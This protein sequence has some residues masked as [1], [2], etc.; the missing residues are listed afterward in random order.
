MYTSDIPGIGSRFY[1]MITNESAMR[2][3]ARTAILLSSQN[4]ARLVQTHKRSVYH[5]HNW[6]CIKRCAFLHHIIVTLR[7]STNL[8]RET[9]QLFSMEHHLAFPAD[10][11]FINEQR[12][13]KCEEILWTIVY[14]IYNLFYIFNKIQPLFIFSN[15]DGYQA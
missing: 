2:L 3:P 10:A 9:W 7:Q 14:G 8:F 12:A 5:W 13:F 1:R 6:A 11:S 15:T 4:L